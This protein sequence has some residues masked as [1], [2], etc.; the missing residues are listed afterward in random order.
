MLVSRGHSEP[1]VYYAVLPNTG[2]IY[3]IRQPPFLIHL[4]T[5]ARR[6]QAQILDS[7]IPV[8]TDWVAYHYDRSGSQEFQ[9]NYSVIC[10]KL[11]SHSGVG[12]LVV[13]MGR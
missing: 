7:Y 5:V 12:W 4:F 11:D 1:F 6:Y 9:I 13:L 8:I 10:I 3:Q 2:Q